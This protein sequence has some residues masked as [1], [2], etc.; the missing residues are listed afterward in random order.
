MKHVCV[1]DKTICL[2]TQ[3]CRLAAVQ[4]RAMTSSSVWPRF[5]AGECLSTLVERLPDLTKFPTKIPLSLWLLDLVYD[6]T[7][8]ISVVY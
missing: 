6:F 2:D 4:A 3:L 7:C 8:G 1:Y 5:V